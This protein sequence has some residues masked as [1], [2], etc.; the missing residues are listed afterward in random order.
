MPCAL[1][2][3]IGLIEFNIIVYAR[4]TASVKSSLS[5]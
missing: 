5:T 1:F 4:F 3:R 2:F